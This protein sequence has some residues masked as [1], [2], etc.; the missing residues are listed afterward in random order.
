MSTTSATSRIIFFWSSD[1]GHFKLSFAKGH[2]EEIPASDNA[3]L[4][5]VGLDRS[6]KKLQLVNSFNKKGKNR[7]GMVRGE[8]NV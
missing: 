3:D 1:N 5:D 4:E 2:N 7:S 8:K 6:K